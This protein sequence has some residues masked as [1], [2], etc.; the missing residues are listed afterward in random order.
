MA[1]QDYLHNL[2]D[3]FSQPQNNNVSLKVL[4]YVD[5]QNLRKKHKN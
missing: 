4:Y 5:Y 2:R 3:T 1:N